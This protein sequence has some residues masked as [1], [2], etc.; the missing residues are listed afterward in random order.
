[1][2][3]ILRNKNLA[4]KFQVLVE[5]A[6]RGP[7]LQQRDIAR[8]L[9]VTPQA[10]SEHVRQLLKEGLLTSEERSHYHVTNEGVNW[11]IAVLREMRSYHDLVERAITNIS[12]SAAIADTAL[13]QGQKVGLEMRNGLLVATGEISGGGSGIACMDAQAGEDVG[14]SDIEGIVGMEIGKVVIVKVPGVQRGGSRAVDIE[15][16][17]SEVS[18]K[19]IVGA[20]GIEAIVALEKSGID[21]FYTYGVIEAAVE[22][23]HRGLSAAIVCVDEG[24]SGL[25][26]RLNEENIDYG[27]IDISQT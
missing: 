19:G 6:D 13:Y 7:N 9:N 1:M 25:I 4:T 15:R 27:I 3:E 14:I 12:V 10:I 22:A 23:A 2:V 24:T 17:R 26:Q 5:I 11:I 18:R 16:L 8:T 21:S 20:I